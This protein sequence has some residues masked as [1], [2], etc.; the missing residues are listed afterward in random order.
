M[1]EN[2]ASPMKNTEAAFSVEPADILHA[3]AQIARLGEVLEAEF[4]LIA[5][6]MS[7]LV[8]SESYLSSA[9]AKAIANY[10]PDHPVTGGLR[11]LAWALPFVGVILAV[12]V[13]V[14]ILAAFSA[15]DTLKR[16][17]DRM[18]AGLP[19][20]LRIHLI[21]AR[22]RQ[23][24]WGNLPAHVLPPILFLVWAVAYAFILIWRTRGQ[25][26]ALRQMVDL[27]WAVEQ[28]G[29]LKT[30]GLQPA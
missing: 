26:D 27:D 19:A 3:L 23:H 29:P 13:Y 17:R 12:C 15:I 4:D 22:S 2:Q 14:A 24:W 18:M 10:R 16:Q 20:K 7:W 11:F 5:G 6:R 28:S 8:L 21:S 9:F 30:G 25:V 1:A